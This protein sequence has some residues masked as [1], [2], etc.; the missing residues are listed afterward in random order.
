MLIALALGFG[1][2]FQAATVP[3]PLDAATP[4]S[5]AAFPGNGGT[6]PLLI[7]AA[8]LQARLTQPDDLVVVDLSDPRR[9]RAEHVPGAV[10]GWWQ[11]TMSPN[12]GVYGRRVQAAGG[13]LGYRQL[14]QSLGIDRESV[15]VAYD[16]DAN[17]YAARFVWLLRLFGLEHA[18]VLDG[19]LAA[20]KGAGFAVSDESSTPATVARLSVDDRDAMVI[21]TDELQDRLGDPS[22]VILDARSPAEAS[23]DLNGTIRV[24]K[25]PGAVWLP[26]NETVVDASGRLRSP[27]ALASRLQAAGVTPDKEIVVYGRFGVEAGQPWLV[28]SLLGYDRIRVYDEGWASWVANE[29][30]PIETLPNANEGPRREG[31]ATSK[32]SALRS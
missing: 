5:V 20:W 16:D 17:R 29:R 24:G 22:L 2:L 8:S 26:W 12:A 31:R 23:D 32:F 13:S 25:I 15:V 21:T 9:Y 6:T 4:I 19:G 28:L 10:H 7:D 27:G 30:R 1:W 18:M 3:L 14:F 11:D